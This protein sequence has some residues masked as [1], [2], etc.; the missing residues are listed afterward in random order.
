MDLYVATNEWLMYEF[1]RAH[2]TEGLDG[3]AVTIEEGYCK[4]PISK[5]RIAETIF[6]TGMAG[7]G[8]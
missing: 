1:L 4:L 8:R 6:N 3:V 2:G 5:E 7:D